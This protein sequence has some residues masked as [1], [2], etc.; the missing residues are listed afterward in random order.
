MVCDKGDKL[1]SG[2]LPLQVIHRGVIRKVWSFRDGPHTISQHLMLFSNFKP[3]M[4]AEQLLLH[5]RISLT[6]NLHQPV[7]LKRLGKAVEGLA[8]VCVDAS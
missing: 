6:Q 3:K 1:S 8:E 4:Y 2:H 7:V 5:L